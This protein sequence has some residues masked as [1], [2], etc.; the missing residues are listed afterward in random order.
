MLWR[1]KRKGA[2]QSTNAVLVCHSVD[3]TSSRSVLASQPAGALL[4]L[5][6]GEGEG[7]GDWPEDI[8]FQA[9]C[10]PCHPMADSQSFDSFDW[11]PVICER[12][13]E[14]CDRIKDANG[15]ANHSATR[16][17]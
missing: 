11:R 8:L 12:G 17:A 6:E 13:S 16:E 7:E 9:S 10:S 1:D 15:H 4:Y 2:A 3:R 5:G 14:V